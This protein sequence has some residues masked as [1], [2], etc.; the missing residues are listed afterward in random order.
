M[1][2][3]RVVIDTDPGVD[4]AAAILLALATPEIEVA[5]ITTVAGNVSLAKTSINAL[6]ICELADVDVPVAAGAAHPLGHVPRRDAYESATARLRFQG[7]SG[8]A[9][10]RGQIWKSVHG[11]DG[12]GGSPLPAPTRSLLS[13]HAADLIAELAAQGPLTIV[14]IAPLTNIALLLERHPSAVERIERFVIMGG[15]R[16]KGNMSAVAEFNVWSDPEAAF[17]VFA[18]G[19]PITLLP[20][21]ITHQAV[22]TVD[23]LEELR[24]TG[25]I[26]SA[27]AAMIVSY[28]RNHKR[29]YGAPF[30]PLHDVL[31]SL[32]LSRPDAM[33]FV[34]AALTVDH[35]ISITRGATLID[36]SDDPAVIKN[37]EVGVMLERE[38]FAH[39]LIDAVKELEARKAVAY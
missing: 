26:G 4:D 33:T 5:A 2:R 22:L 29:H 3:R 10:V 23:E 24:H 20:L 36:T 34:R 9:H 15:A 13:A 14:G 12:L 19:V 18:S 17:R 16:T 37:A 25:E 1:T 31:A 11:R 28:G 35:G 32:Y 7:R 39:A 30:M 38:L 21:E 6:R 27:L 8:V